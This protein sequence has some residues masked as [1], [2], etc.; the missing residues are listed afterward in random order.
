MLLHQRQPTTGKGPFQWTR[1][2]RLGGAVRGRSDGRKRRPDRA[3]RKGLEHKSSA[4]RS[5]GAGIRAHLRFHAELEGKK[6]FS[7]IVDRLVY[8]AQ[9][10]RVV[11]NWI[12]K[13]YQAHSFGTED[14]ERVGAH[15]Y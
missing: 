12:E 5:F 9:G 13:R 10:V 8:L 3:K 2:G 14:V 4:V 6:F 11:R 15:P 7:K 1:P